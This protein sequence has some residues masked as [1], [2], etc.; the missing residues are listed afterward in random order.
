MTQYECL[1]CGNRD[2]VPAAEDRGERVCASCGG[3]MRNLAL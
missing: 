1:A 2:Q 3:P